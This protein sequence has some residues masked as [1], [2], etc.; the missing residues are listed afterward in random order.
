MPTK[1][2][3]NLTANRLRKQNLNFLK[4]KFFF[5]IKLSKIAYDV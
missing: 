3:N 5:W 1:K 4:K 2:H